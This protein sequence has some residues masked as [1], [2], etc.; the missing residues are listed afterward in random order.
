MARVV[1]AG[2]GD[3]RRARRAAPATA[4]SISPQV[5]LVG[6]RRG[7]AGRARRRRSRRSRARARWCISATNASSST[8][9]SSSNGVTIAVR[10]A[11]KP[12]TAGM[13]TFA[14]RRDEGC[15]RAS[16]G[17]T[18]RR[19][20][21]RCSDRCR[22][23]ARPSARPACRRAARG[24]GVA[25]GSASA[26]SALV[27]RAER[28]SCCA[29][30]RSLN[31]SAPRRASLRLVGELLGAVEKTHQPSSVPSCVNRRAWRHLRDRDHGRGH[32]R[33]LARRRRGFAVLAA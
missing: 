28:G 3:D 22:I 19:A 17:A 11:P 12:L 4:S 1:G 7:L 25:A 27:R 13:P 10:M 32:G 2:A 31:W 20:D 9:S 21:R 33:A 23:P 5:L 29:C 16:S 24:L 14:A 26:R 30:W 15:W 6:Q 8:R 18:G